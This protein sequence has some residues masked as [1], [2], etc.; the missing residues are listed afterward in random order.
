MG[1]NP[2]WQVLKVAGLASASSM[3]GSRASCRVLAQE[4]TEVGSAWM[5]GEGSMIGVCASFESSAEA[6]PGLRMLSSSSCF[7]CSCAVW[8]LSS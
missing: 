1:K 7:F 6:S 3:L 4:F 5:L 2:R 8:P